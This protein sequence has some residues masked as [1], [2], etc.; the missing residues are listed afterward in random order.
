MAQTNEKAFESCLEQML[1]TGGWQPGTNAEWDQA[2]ELK[3]ILG[4]A[5]LTPSP[6]R[7]R[8]RGTRSTLRVI[9]R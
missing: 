7:R 3:S 6:S 8:E 4:A 9:S 1:A 5:A 2:R